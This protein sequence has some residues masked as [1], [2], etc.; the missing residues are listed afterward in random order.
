[1]TDKKPE[2]DSLSSEPFIS[3]PRPFVDA[4]GAI[5]PL[6]EGGFHSVQ[7]IT[8]KAGTVRANHFHKADSHYMYVVSGS[9]RYYAR[10]AGTQDPP[11][12]VLVRAGQMV[13]TPP[14]VEHAVH[15]PEDCVFLNVTSKPRD[16]SSYEDDI[17]RVEL[18][19]P[20]NDAA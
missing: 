20:Q 19:R 14:L 13:F 12:S 15:F 7:I 9:M 10:A 2:T 3:L 17:V 6:V 18:F 16:Q 4:R 1:M 5:Q 8:S 11:R